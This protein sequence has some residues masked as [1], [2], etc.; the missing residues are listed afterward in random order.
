MNERRSVDWRKRSEDNAELVNGYL[1]SVTYSIF[2]W[3]GKGTRV[4]NWQ[5]KDLEV[6]TQDEKLQLQN[7]EQIMVELGL[8]L[9]VLSFNPA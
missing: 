3:Q 7:R 9:N 1:V 5:K 6:K 4:K 2:R 8:S